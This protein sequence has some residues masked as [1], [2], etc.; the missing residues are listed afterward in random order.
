MKINQINIQ[1]NISNSAYNNT[2]DHRT[3]IKDN[4]IQGGKISFSDNIGTVT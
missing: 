2:L 1:I 4:G 3:A